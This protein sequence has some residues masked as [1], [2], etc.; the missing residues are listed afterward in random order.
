MKQLHYGIIGYGLNG[1]AHVLENSIHPH[2]KNRMKVVAGFDPDPSKMEKIKDKHIKAA[3][4][5]DDLLATPGIE[6]IMISSPPQHHA[7]QVV[8][9]MESG[10]HVFSEVPMALKIEDVERIIHAEDENKQAIYQF[11]ENYAFISEILYA[12]KLVA[13]GTLGPVVYC[14]CEYLHD[15]TY[16][17]R[18]GGKGGPDVPKVDS[19]YSLFD[20][21]MYGHAIGPAQLAMGGGKKPMPFVEVQSYANSIGGKDGKPICEPANSFHVGLFKSA[22]G[23]IARCAAAYIFAREP[24]RRYFTITGEL[25]TFESPNPGGKSYLF[26]ADDHD[27]NTLRHRSGS[28]TKI[29]QFKLSRSIPPEIGGHWGGN[30]RVKKDWLDAIEEG[31][32]PTFHAKAAANICIAGIAASESARTG[33]AVKIKVFE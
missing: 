27:I 29:G 24:A 16:R 3:D 7:S 21:L 14:E 6:A 1:W 10:L 5:L 23:A 2:L 33:R 13:D 8:A 20:P 25:G 15:V 17:W 26:L 30:V 4:S 19:W 32:K 31:R 11:G 22:S 28:K 12:G 9:A 18:Q